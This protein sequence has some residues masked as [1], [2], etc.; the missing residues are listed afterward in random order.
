MTNFKDFF[1]IKESRGSLLL[2][3]M[4]GL[5]AFAISF[6]V[7]LYWVDVTAQNPS[8]L[9]SETVMINTNDGYY[10]AEGAK[11][12][13]GGST[14]SINSPIDSPVSILTAFVYKITPFSFETILLY[15][16]AILGSLVVI[17]LL[18]IG[19]EIGSVEGGF[20]AAVIGSIAHSYYNRT[21]AGYY[22][23]DMLVMPFAVCVAFFYILLFRKDSYLNLF[24]VSIFIIAGLCYYPNLRFVFIGFGAVYLGL[25]LLERRYKNSFFLLSLLPLLVVSPIYDNYIKMGLLSI[26]FLFILSP[27]SKNKTLLYG[28]L[29]VSVLFFAYF[30]FFSAILEFLGRDYFKRELV[31][32]SNMT[33]LSYYS[34]VN[35]IREAG[36]IPFSVFADR[37]SGSVLLFFFSLLGTLL[38]A[39]YDRRF[40]IMLPLLVLGYFA[41]RGGLRFTIYAVPVQALGFGFLSVY[42]AS[43]VQKMVQGRKSLFFGVLFVSLVGGAYPNVAHIVEYKVPTVF[44][45]SEVESL[46]ELNALSKPDDFAL[47]WWDYGY[48]IRY[49]GDVNTFIDGGK[50][51]GS[52]NFVVSLALSTSSER[53]ASNIAK[54]YATYTMELHNKEIN[55]TIPFLDYEM[56]DYGFSNPY[57]FI[58]SMELGVTKSSFA[59]DI[60]FVLPFRMLEIL[61]TVYRFSEVD[62]LSGDMQNQGFYLFSNRFRDMGDRIVLDRGVLVDKRSGSLILGDKNI[63]L[64]RFVTVFEEEGGIKVDESRIH[65]SSPLSLVYLKNYGAFVVMDEKI[66]NSVYIKL[67]L[68]EEYDASIFEQVIISPLMKIYKLK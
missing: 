6:G 35:T 51:E 7:R 2:A 46:E 45:S 26:I 27:F 64:K 9:Y 41:L 19:R 54:M 24:L 65:T 3:L 11:D 57:D 15:M 53:L 62:L 14:P 18:L 36:N 8:A 61:P 13:L 33:L 23:S 32:E 40:L 10:F 31:S 17:P 55:S 42:I 12:I 44:S 1:G 16:P 21:M 52:D 60:Y 59:G 47:S 38:L 28:A 25:G 43:S 5:I 56:R 4:L 66:Y 50:H 58:E 37:I 49:Y 67:F 22:D 30:G 68:F 29:G 39:I 34:V 48:P 63:P 20:I